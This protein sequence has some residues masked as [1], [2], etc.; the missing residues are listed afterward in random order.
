MA[1][2]NKAGGILQKIIVRKPEA[3]IM[4]TAEKKSEQKLAETL[5][6]K[7]HFNIKASIKYNHSRGWG[8]VVGGYED[9]KRRFK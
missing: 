3:V 1:A 5:S 7:T 9:R 8:F 4:T 6:K 2:R